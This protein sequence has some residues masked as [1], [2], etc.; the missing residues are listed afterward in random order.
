MTVSS[1]FLNEP[2]WLRTW[3]HRLLCIL[4]VL[5]CANVLYLLRRDSYDFHVGPVHLLAHGFFKPTLIFYTIFILAILVKRTARR[6]EGLPAFK[7]GHLVLLLAAIGVG[8]F[9]ATSDINPIYDEWNYRGFSRDLDGHVWTLFVTPQFSS[10][11]R[12]LG[13]L[14]LWM[15][16]HIFGDHLWGYHLQNIVWHLV[17][18]YLAWVLALRL[19]LSE[20]VAGWAAIL[21]ACAAVTYEPIMWPSARFDLLAMA[22]TAIALIAAIDYL[23]QGKA[24]SVMVTTISYVLAV[25][26]KE[27]GYAF[28]ILLVPIV[29]LVGRS[30]R[31]N[32]R[33]I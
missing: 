23:A 27:S 16:S 3:V 9:F 28:P 5:A 1:S 14:S 2:N 12:P 22:F 17:N 6:S 18:A 11:Y 31:D 20:S 21:F 13:F 4:L 10:W 7:P 8:W 29:F 24:V 25:I 33:R 19:R 26:S 30:W 32:L 15:D